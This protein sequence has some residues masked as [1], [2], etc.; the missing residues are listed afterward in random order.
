[1]SWFPHRWL[2]GKRN[3]PSQELD[4]VSLKDGAKDTAESL[5]HPDRLNF[6]RPHTLCLH[7]VPNQ[8]QRVTLILEHEGKR[9]QGRI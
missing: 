4:L 6:T 2:P 7:F 9:V 3:S 1:M 5:G 8:I